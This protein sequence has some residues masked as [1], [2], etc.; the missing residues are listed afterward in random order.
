MERLE[1]LGPPLVT[2]VING[3]N[4]KKRPKSQEMAENQWINNRVEKK[5]LLI[6]QRLYTPHLYLTGK[7]PILAGEIEVDARNVW[8]LFKGFALEN[9]A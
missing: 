7:D 2:I 5:N 4:H 8:Y 9:G 3:R 6:G 1:T